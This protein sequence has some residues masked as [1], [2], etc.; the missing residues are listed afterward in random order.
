MKLSV[1]VPVYNEALQLETVVHGLMR[2][3]CPLERE[4]LFV[5]D[6]STD[7]SAEIL[8]R[9]AAQYPAMRVIQQP[10]NMGKGA[11]AIRGFTEATGDILMIQDAD[12]EY[13]PDDVP[14]LLAPILAGKADVVYG[15]RFKKSAPQIH[16]TFHYFVN[17][18]LTVVSNVLSGLYLTDM[19]TCYKVFRAPL[20]KGMRLRSQRFG[21]EVELT[22]YVAKSPARVHELP[23]AYYPRTQLQ[24]KKINWR[25]GVAALW[26]LVHFN[27]L[28]KPEQAFHVAPAAL[29]PT[30]G[31]WGRT[32]A[33]PMGVISES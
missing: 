17:R 24:G 1:I 30:P 27:L 4:W 8:T 14:S 16:R 19:E 5:N 15:S 28:V 31:P 3:P 33:A 9:L 26:H 12:F 18:F 13:D 7:G 25:D 11:A 23:I 22:A 32:P 6:C 20:V 10:H 29:L 21:I 2:S